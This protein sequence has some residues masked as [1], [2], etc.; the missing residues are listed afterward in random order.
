MGLILRL[1]EADF[2]SSPS[3]SS[4]I[5][6]PPPGEDQLMSDE[7]STEKLPQ[8]ALALQVIQILTAVLLTLRPNNEEAAQQVLDFIKRHAHLFSSILKDRYGLGFLINIKKRGTVVAY[9]LVQQAHKGSH[10]TAVTSNGH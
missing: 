10:C 2:L 9:L 4:A 5:V 6:A 8:Q 1:A 7:I 3:L